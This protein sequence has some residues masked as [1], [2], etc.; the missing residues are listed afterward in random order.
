MLWVI[1]TVLG[2]FHSETNKIVLGVKLS[3][4]CP[5]LKT[6]SKICHVCTMEA[7]QSCFVFCIEADYC[8]VHVVSFASIL[9]CSSVSCCI[10]FFFCQSI[11]SRI[12]VSHEISLDHGNK[13]VESHS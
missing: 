2:L 3:A 10:L 1:L 11:E 7:V 13:T 6:E 9:R 12:P 4:T 5:W 8:A